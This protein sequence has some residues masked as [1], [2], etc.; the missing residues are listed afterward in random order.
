MPSV[1]YGDKIINYT[2]QEDLNLASH[3]ISVE[4]RS[5]VVLKGKPLPLELTDRLILKKAKWILD[6]LTL[7]S[8]TEHADIVTGSRIPYIGKHFYAEVVFSNE[9]QDCTVSFNHSQ[10]KIILN[11]QLH[12]QE[13]ILEALEAFYRAKAVEKIT[14]RVKRLSKVLGLPYTAL[15]FRKMEKRWGSCTSNNTIILNY[16]AIKLPFS[17]IDYLICHELCHTVVKTIQRNSGL[18]WRSIC[19]TGSS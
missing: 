18:N 14:S 11:P 2:L 9:A 6:K 19:R 3:Y 7:V 4:K 8:S 15:K 1:T 16:E 12:G 5:G 13:T 17:L 10:F